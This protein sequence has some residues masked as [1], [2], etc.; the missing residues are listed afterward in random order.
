MRR[1]NL[2]VR[3]WSLGTRIFSG[4]TA[5]S[6]VGYSYPRGPVRR[7]YAGE[8]MLCGEAINS[9]QLLQLS[10]VSATPRHIFKQLAFDELDDGE[11]SP[12]PDMQTD[13]QILDWVARDAETALHPS[14]ICKMGV[15]KM[16]VVNPT[17]IKVH[18]PDCLRHHTALLMPMSP[19]A[20]C[21]LSS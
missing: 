14:C 18:G 17:D 10:G 5:R 13:E 20:R 7:A 21:T 2:T 4:V 1:R 3:C 16:S 8:V 9:P 12:G 15:E 19:T 11:L 6:G